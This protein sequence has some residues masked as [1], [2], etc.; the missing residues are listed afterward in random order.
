MAPYRSLPTSIL[1]DHRAR[2]AFIHKY[3][4]STSVLGT[5]LNYVDEWRTSYDSAFKDLQIIMR[6]IYFIIHTPHLVTSVV[7]A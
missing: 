4:L 3:L 2:V 5:K 1:E 7:S 6:D